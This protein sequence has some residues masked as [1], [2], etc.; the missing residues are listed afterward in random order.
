MPYVIVG[1]DV[2][3][4]ASRRI[5]L[6]HLQDLVKY[7]QSVW[8]VIYDNVGKTLSPIH[9]EWQAHIHVGL[10]GNHCRGFFPAGIVPA[11]ATIEF[12]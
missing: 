1:F 7:D 6:M 11:A 2:Q 4:G 10:A 3:D 12:V 9:E 8:R 5:D